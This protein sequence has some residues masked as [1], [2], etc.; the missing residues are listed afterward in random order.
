L[1]LPHADPY[2][3]FW[4]EDSGPQFNLDVISLSPG[5]LSRIEPPQTSANSM[6]IGLVSVK[7]YTTSAEQRRIA[8]TVIQDGSSPCDPILLLCGRLHE[9]KNWDRGT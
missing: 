8:D 2:H 1:S 6:V 5:R 9:N 3:L 4:D 7:K